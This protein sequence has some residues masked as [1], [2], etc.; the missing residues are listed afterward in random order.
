MQIARNTPKAF[1]LEALCFI[2]SAKIPESLLNLV[3]LLYYV[4]TRVNGD[5]ELEGVVGSGLN[6]NNDNDNLI[7]LVIPY[8]RVGFI[9]EWQKK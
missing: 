8:L 3:K 2:F 1:R 5:C 7:F 6:C 4:K 9:Y